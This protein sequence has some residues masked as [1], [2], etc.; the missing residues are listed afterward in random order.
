MNRW[1]ARLR[2][3]GLGP[4]DGDTN[5][6]VMVKHRAPRDH[7]DAAAEL[8]RRRDILGTRM[9]AA[10]RRVWTPYAAGIGYQKIARDLG[11]TDHACR[12]TIANVERGFGRRGRSTCGALESL[13]ANVDTMILGRLFGAMA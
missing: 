2:R 8:D 5:T 7:A 6:T 10:E 11:I 1:E 4:L 9:T 13:I 3:E 12:T